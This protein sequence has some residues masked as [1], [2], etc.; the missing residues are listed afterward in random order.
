MNWKALRLLIDSKLNP[1]PILM[2][3]DKDEKGEWYFNYLDLF[4]ARF[5]YEKSNNLKRQ[6]LLCLK[7]HRDNIVKANKKYGSIEKLAIK[8]K[9]ITDFHNRFCKIRGFEDYIIE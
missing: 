1:F 8:Y 2:G 4:Y 3:H 6:F 7:N 5:Y 9:W